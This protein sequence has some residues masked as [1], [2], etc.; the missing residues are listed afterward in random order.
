[1]CQQPSVMPSVSP[2][3]GVRQLQLLMFFEPGTLPP[4]S[5]KAVKRGHLATTHKFG[6]EKTD[7]PV[8]DGEANP[9]LEGGAGKTG[10]AGPDVELGSESLPRPLLVLRMDLFLKAVP[11]CR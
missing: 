10:G 8:V 11:A 6:D 7:A 5:E 3:H 9:D 1:M 2:H 4:G